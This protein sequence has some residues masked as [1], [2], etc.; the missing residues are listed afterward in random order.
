MAHENSNKKNNYK[1][2]L[3]QIY[4]QIESIKIRGLK[5]FYFSTCALTFV[6]SF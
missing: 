2:L 4:H 1:F 5:F 3:V 6:R